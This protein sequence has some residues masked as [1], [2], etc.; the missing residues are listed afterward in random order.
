MSDKPE[1]AEEPNELYE[2]FRFV[3]DKGQNSLRI[4]KYLFSRI[5]NISRTRLQNAANAG[6][7]LVNG[8]PV[9]PSYKIRPLDTITIVLAHPPR[10]TE[11]YPEDI[12]VK[13]EYEDTDIIVVNKAAGM[14]SIPA[15][16]ILPEP[17]K[18]LCYSI[19]FNLIPQGRP[20][21][22]WSTELTRILRAYSW[23]QRTN[24][25]RANWQGSSFTIRSSAPMPH[26]FGGT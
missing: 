8:Q 16:E 24:L 7:I 10:D 14:V 13:I 12:P 23:L 11:I 21:H 4:D 5:E 19:C 17:C 6:N 1:L 20:N 25:P 22:F 26:L 15:T 2:H 3:V 18:M 9:K